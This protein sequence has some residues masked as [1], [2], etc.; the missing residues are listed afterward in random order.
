MPPLPQTAG[1]VPNQKRK[2]MTTSSEQSSERDAM[3]LMARQVAEGSKTLGLHIKQHDDISEAAQMWARD[4]I[5]ESRKQL[6]ESHKQVVEEAVKS[7]N[8]TTELLR[9]DAERLTAQLGEQGARDAASLRETASKLAET[10]EELTRRLEAGVKTAENA[11]N[12]GAELLLEE[13]TSF[14]E[15][16]AA[17]AQEQL[18]QQAENHKKL[19]EQ[20]E[21]DLRQDRQRQLEEHRLFREE[22]LGI[23][24]AEIEFALEQASKT[25]REALEQAGAKV[26]EDNRANAGSAVAAINRS[27]SGFAKTVIGAA[28]ISSVVAIAVAAALVTLT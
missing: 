13:H 2:M 21:E 16:A 22:T 24:K 27:W 3:S 1:Q 8:A 28:I 12:R 4:V 6:E 15:K 5:T 18:E 7:F 10:S 26:N 9:Q 25:N 19:R 11:I 17:A 23:L 14:L 20:Q